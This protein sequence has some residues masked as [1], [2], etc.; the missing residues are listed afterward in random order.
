MSVLKD[1]RGQWSA[2][3]IF[4]AVWLGNSLVLVWWRPDVSNAVLAFL[5]S[6]GMA[7]VTWAAGPRI[8]AY[9]APQIAAAAQAVG[10]AKFVPHAWKDGKEDGI[11]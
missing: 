4:A 7:L 6:I 1:E 11:L 9:L 8:A 2:A 10:Q 5:T 3:R